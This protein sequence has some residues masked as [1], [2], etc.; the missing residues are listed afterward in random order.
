MIPALIILAG[1]ILIATGLRLF[2]HIAFSR[3]YRTSAPA[4]AYHHIEKKYGF[5]ATKITAWQFESQML[6]LKKRDYATLS[7]DEFIRLNGKGN[8]RSVLITFDDSYES[9]FT[10]A[11]PLLKSLDF[12]ATLFIIAGFIGRKSTWDVHFRPPAHMT[13]DEIRKAL[14]L[15]FTLGSHTLNHPDLTYLPPARLKEEL[16]GSK[17]VLEDAFCQEIRYLAYPFGRYNERVKEAARECGYRAAFTINRPMRQTAFDPYCIPVTG[18]YGLD[19]MRNFVSKLER[20]GYF[21]VDAMRDKIINRF[22]SGTTLV[23][24]SKGA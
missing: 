6:E 23:K 19:T 22:A 10:N 7:P 3:N 4:L 14:E 20:N 13:G 17:K 24:G 2:A 18:I 11:I 9:V 8:N 5:P 15:G 21:W 1:F 12:T 16:S